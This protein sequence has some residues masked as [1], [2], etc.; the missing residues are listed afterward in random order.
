MQCQ[1]NFLLDYSNLLHHHQQNMIHLS[2]NLD[3]Q[4]HLL[5]INLQ[6]THRGILHRLQPSTNLEA[7]RTIQRLHRNLGHPTTTQLHKLLVERNA[8]ERLLQANQAFKCE[9][10]S[11]R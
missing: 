8:N 2:F 5:N 10:C 3:F 1:M 11:Q 7:Q 4:I 6:P 9:H